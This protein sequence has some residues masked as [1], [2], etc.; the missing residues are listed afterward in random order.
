MIA[1]RS[2]ADLLVGEGAV[3]GAELEP[4][5]EALA[6]LP[7][8][9]ASIEVEDLGRVQQLATGGEDRRADLG[10]GDLL[11]D[12]DREVLVDRGEGR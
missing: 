2:P 1:P 11:G 7:E 8:L 5:G 4:E 3:G 10:G 6:P 12:D 9:L